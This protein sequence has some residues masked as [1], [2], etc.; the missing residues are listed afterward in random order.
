MPWYP[1][2]A[3]DAGRMRDN[4]RHGDSSGDSNHC[5][6][7]VAEAASCDMELSRWRK[8]LCGLCLTASLSSLRQHLLQRVFIEECAGRCLEE[9]SASLWQLLYWTKSTVKSRRTVARLVSLLTK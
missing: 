7:I 4:S 9:T 3:P 8:L 6:D 2:Q 1:E 5:N